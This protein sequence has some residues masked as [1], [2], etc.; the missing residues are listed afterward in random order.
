[1]Q[2]EKEWRSFFKANGPRTSPRTPE[3][4]FIWSTFSVEA[5]PIVVGDSYIEL[6]MC[7]EEARGSNRLFQSNKITACLADRGYA[8]HQIGSVESQSSLQ[9]R[10]VDTSSTAHNYTCTLL[11]WVRK[12]FPGLNI[13]STIA[14]TENGHF[15]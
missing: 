14:K 4:N 15:D 5:E 2:L 13:T 9:A 12:G 7:L 6:H 8:S 11:I 3:V 10:S 1:M